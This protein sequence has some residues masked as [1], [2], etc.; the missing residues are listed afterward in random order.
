AGPPGGGRPGGARRAAATAAVS[1]AGGASA[2]G[3][4]AATAGASRSPIASPRVRGSGGPEPP[5]AIGRQ[6]EPVAAAQHGLDDLR[7]GWIV[8]DLAAQVLHVRVDGALIPLEL[9]SS[10]PADEFEP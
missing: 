9:V 8:L 3:A 5:S 1:P 6:A 4:T 7:V 10:H 2:A